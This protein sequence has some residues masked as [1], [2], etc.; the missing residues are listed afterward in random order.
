MERNEA[1]RN[2]VAFVRKRDKRVKAEKKRREE[3]EVLEKK[4]REQPKKLQRHQEL[5]ECGEYSEWTKFDKFKIELE[6]LKECEVQE[7]GDNI[8]SEAEEVV[9]T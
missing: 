9:I 8:D 5:N 6:N 4:K 3:K 1:I 7:F 2:L